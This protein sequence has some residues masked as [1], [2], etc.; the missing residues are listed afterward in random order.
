MTNDRPV[1]QANKAVVVLLIALIFLATGASGLIYQV[2]WQRYFLNTFGATIYSVSAVLS[3]FMGGLA[4]GSVIIGRLADKMRRPLAFYGVMEI[5]VGLAAL[6]VPYLLRLL[7][8]VFHVA[9]ENFGSQFFIYSIVRFVFVFLM[10]LIP[11]TLMGSTLPVLS[12][13][14][15]GTEADRAGGRVG[16]LYAVNT[17]GAV[18]GAF[19]CGFYFIRWWGVS[20]TVMLAAALNG[21]A[22]VV[23]LAISAAT[24]PLDVSATDS[25]DEP[26]PG[27]RPLTRLVMAAYAVSGFA[28]LSLEVVWSRS[29]IFTFENLKNTTY[30]FTC[31]LTTFLVG[32]TLGS[33][34]MTPFANR[35]K[36]PLRAFAILQI[37][38]G[39][40]SIT[41]FF[42]L[43]YVAHSFGNQWLAELDNHPGNIRWN[44]A[45]ALVFLKSA[46]VVG[47]PTF[48]MGLAFPVAVR[49][50]QCTQANVGA[51][52]GRLYA[53]NTLGAIIGAAS[54]GFIL[55]PHL[56]IANTILLM[57]GL[58]MLAG[59]VCIWRD[60]ASDA[61][62][63]VTWGLLGAATIAVAL[64]RLPRPA[65]MQEINAI[66]KLVSYEE[67]PLATVSVVQNSLG[68]R[69]INVDNVGVA[70]TDPML[71]TDQ[72]SLAHVPMLLLPNPK[73]AL[74][75]GFGSG[76]ASY[77]YTL[78]PQLER[79]DCV[80]I[81]NTVP[82]QAPYLQDSNKGVIFS[83]DPALEQEQRFI[84]GKPFEQA[85]AAHEYYPLGTDKLG[86][87]WYKADKRYNVILDDARSYL[88][89]TNQRYSAI[90]TD[91][92]DLRY[93]SN[94]NL[95]DLQYF[96]LCRDRITD[97]G[98]VVVWMPLA[99]L[100]D[101]AMK[102][103]LRTF[104]KVFPNM[105]VFF[106][107]NQPTHYVLLIGTKAPLKV[108]VDLMNQRL[109]VPGVK[110]DLAEIHL[111]SAEKILSC[112]VT[113]GAQM[114]DYLADSPVQALNTEDFPYLEFESPRF[115]YSDEP[116]LDNL[117]ELYKF[118]ADAT[119]L[120]A[121]PAQHQEFM[122]SLR[123]YLEATP[124]IIKGHRNYR[125]V[126]LTQACADYMKALEINPADSSVKDLLNFEE[127]RRKIRG[128]G[129]ATWARLWMG[130]LLL[131]QN[132][133]S[134]AVSVLNELLAQPMPAGDA[135]VPGF[136]SEARALLA[137]IYEDA[138]QPEKARAY[139]EAR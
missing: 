138:G 3:A 112:Y 107:N 37:L 103:A 93:K 133:T 134:E 9:Y 56:G 114:V 118:G 39:L 116:L 139:R 83:T 109:Q 45:V 18:V 33:A 87:N 29:L 2:V 123:K 27:L 101:A 117:D 13:Y 82:R 85:A 21:A 84:G 48:F 51:T 102:V 62:R 73:S 17:A 132:R 30:S 126:N 71:L 136:Y 8:P 67:G 125:E 91:C 35:I 41:S 137:K 98:M 108:D 69:T 128:Q 34:V 127:L 72:K 120:V 104:H 77:S 88:R 47:P 42:V 74:T 32:I 97:D 66:D 68:Y 79:V 24:P 6:A 53:L 28:A 96:T 11:T 63:R 113:G 115:G 100:S 5:A 111:D 121:N 36:Q 105:E 31:M 15:T 20:H 70:G 59:I 7:E 22:G 106:L 16:L 130:K 49:A 1:S 124:Y 129:A 78:Y 60:P 119:A 131:Q 92:T 64:M 76:G 99:G 81:T 90:A 95:Y 44:A 14:L 38:V 89:F 65:I 40:F 135:N 46:I 50:V 10:L 94:A 110:E 23:A 43:Y 4:L 58:Q 61:T 86:D 75:V 80:E 55:L 122:A 26:T 57:G 12:R 25:A 52:I 54:T 19:L